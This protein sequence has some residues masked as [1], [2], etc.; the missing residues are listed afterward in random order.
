MQGYDFKFKQIQAIL[1]D[2]FIK[3]SK[4]QEFTPCNLNYENGNYFADFKNKKVGSSAIL[5][6]M[7]NVEGLAMTTED[8][9]SK[10]VGDCIDVIII[11]NK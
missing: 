6:N 10:K 11:D 8:D 7:L 5:T 2:D 4:K 9:N 3:K 1:K